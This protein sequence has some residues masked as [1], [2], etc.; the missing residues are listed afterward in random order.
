[1]AAGPPAAACHVRGLATSFAAST[2]TDPPG[3]QSAGASMGFALQGVPRVAM[4]AP[5]GVPALLTLPAA[6]PSLPK[7]GRADDVAAYRALFPRRV[8]AVARP[9]RGR[10]SRRCLPGILPSRAF[11]PAVR[12]IACSRDAGPLVLGRDDV[13]AHLD[14][15]ASRSG[16]IGLVRFRTASSLGVVHLATVTALRSSSRGAGSCFRLT[17]DV[18]HDT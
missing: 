12:A 6:A 8:R 14:L 3:A 18:T 17:Q 15:R 13:P 4:G 2:T 7:E 5:F 10:S 1:V 9:P 11:S 16:W